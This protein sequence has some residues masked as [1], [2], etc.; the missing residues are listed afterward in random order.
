MCVPHLCPSLLSWT[1][2]G[3]P[4]QSPYSIEVLTNFRLDNSMRFIY[5]QCDNEVSYRR[6]GHPTDTSPAGIKKKYLI[7]YL[8]L[9][10]T[11]TEKKET[12][13]QTRE[14]NTFTYTE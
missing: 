9:H 12:I 7:C 2:L 14:K 1:V 4:T 10:I 8:R 5:T 13:K 3:E 6:I 11:I